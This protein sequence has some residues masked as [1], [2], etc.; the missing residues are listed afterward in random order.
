L[1]VEID[2]AYVEPI[3]TAIPE[4]GGQSARWM[5]TA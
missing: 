4:Q 5:R 2:R 3:R 1:A